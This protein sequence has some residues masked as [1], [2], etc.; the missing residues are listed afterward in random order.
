[1]NVTP[2]IGRRAPPPSPDEAPCVELGAGGGFE[3][4]L[5]F[6]GAGF[7]S[8]WSHPAYDYRRYDNGEMVHMNAASGWNVDAPM[9]ATVG[10]GVQKRLGSH[11]ALR[12]D[13]SMG[14]GISDY[15]IGCV[16]MPSIG[17]SMP[18]GRY[19]AAGNVR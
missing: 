17:L 5:T 8:R 16:L 6:G 19:P 11:L 2:A 7:V 9:Y 12:A 14:F 3:P 15:G 4:H 18:I 10:I 1:V 13:I